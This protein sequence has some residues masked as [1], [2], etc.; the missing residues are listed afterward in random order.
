[1]TLQEQ[2]AAMRALLRKV[3]PF[4]TTAVVESEDLSAEIDAL[5]EE[6]HERHEDGSI[7]VLCPACWNDDH[8]GHEDEFQDGSSIKLLCE[9]GLCAYLRES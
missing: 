9:C 2:N 4:I 5:L 6:C 1:M 8:T 7:V 3:Q